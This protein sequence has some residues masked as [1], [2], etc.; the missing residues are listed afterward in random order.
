[1]IT[2]PNTGDR[3][4]VHGLLEYCTNPF[5]HVGTRTTGKGAERVLLS[6]PDWTGE[7]PTQFQAPKDHIKLPTDWVRLIGRV[8]V[9]EPSDV[10]IF[11]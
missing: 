7:V 2:T 1:M 6:G 9:D 3:D 4:Y 5:T 8:L 11:N 10:A